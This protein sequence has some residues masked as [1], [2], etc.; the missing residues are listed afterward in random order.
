MKLGILRERAPGETRVAA[1]PDTVAAYIKLGHAVVGEQAAGMAAGFSDQRYI[2]AGAEIR[3]A[4][5][6][7]NQCDV[8]LSV[9]RPGQEVIDHLRSGTVLI[10][11]LQP[12]IYPELAVTLAA[13]GVTSVSLDAVPRIARAQSMDALSS[14]STVAGY[15]AVLLAANALPRFFPLLMTA[16]GVIPPARVLVIGAGV[17]GLGAIG[18]A[19][20]LGAIVR[21]YDT[22]PAVKEQVESLG[23]TFVELTLQQEKREDTAGYA[24]ALAADVEAQE[25]A[26][27]SEQIRESDIVITTAQVPGQRAP[28]LVPRSAVEAM[29][30]GSVIVDLAA[31][32]GGN[33][34]V[35]V[36]GEVTQHHGVTIIALKNIPAMVPLHASQLYAQNV[37]HLVRHLYSK[38]ELDLDFTDEITRSVCITHAGEVCHPT[39]QALL[40]E[41]QAAAAVNGEGAHRD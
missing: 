24:T 38:G 8:V 39:V 41:K 7:L 3:D 23:A 12:F 31:E 29:L 33:C 32:T 20:R 37:F 22:R 5:A 34:E 9:Q 10:G 26:L 28:V 27:L 15:K 19:R 25:R 11:L 21:A 16:A 1:I 30:P 13:R 18:T 6:L 17:A 2:T 36:P 14:Q 35:S 4:V 40:R